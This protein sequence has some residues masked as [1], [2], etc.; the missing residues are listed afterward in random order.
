MPDA[1]GV[2]VPEMVTEDPGI[3]FEDDVWIVNVGVAMAT[4]TLTTDELA[5]LCSASPGHVDLN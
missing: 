3:I 4:D 1:D 2:I 5:G